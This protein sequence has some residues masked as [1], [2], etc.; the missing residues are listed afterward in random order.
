MVAYNYRGV[1]N[2]YIRG[3]Y[4]NDKGFDETFLTSCRLP[5]ITSLNFGVSY[6]LT[7]DFSIWLQAD[8]LLNRKI[9]ILPGLLSQGVTVAGGLSVVF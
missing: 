2:T 8:N 4:H 7:D 3:T 5:D 1:R 9:D 6:S